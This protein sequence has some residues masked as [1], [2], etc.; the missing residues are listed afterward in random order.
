MV[1]GGQIMSDNR[2]KKGW[3]GCLVTIYRLVELLSWFNGVDGELKK[4]M[5][6][7]VWLEE[8]RPTKDEAFTGDYEV[9]IL[10]CY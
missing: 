3:F 6:L 2:G 10:L 1:D 5:L 9:L 8:K 7:S 4:L